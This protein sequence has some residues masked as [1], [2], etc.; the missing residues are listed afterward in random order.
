M[1]A[2]ARTA[3]VVVGATLIAASG[4][5]APKIDLS[6]MQQPERPAELAAFDAFV[7]K[8]NWQAEM[9]TAEGPDAKWTG[10]AEWNWALDQRWLHGRMSSKTANAEFEAAGVWG[11]HPAKKQYI[12]YLFNN[13]GYPQ[14]GNATYNEQ[15]KTWVMNYTSVGLDGTT[16]HGYYRMTQAGPDLLEWQMHEWADATRMFKK[17]EMT[18]SY[19]RQE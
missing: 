19:Q 8:W 12:W 5:A 6:G 13:W 15:T 10:T 2:T 3:A 9:V 17:L 4:C 16:S 14:E 7:G 11:W 1:R 18:G